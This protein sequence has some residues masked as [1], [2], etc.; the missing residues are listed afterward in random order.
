MRLDLFY[1][2]RNHGFCYEIKF[3]ALKQLIDYKKKRAE[4]KDKKDVSLLD[5]LIRLIDLTRVAGAGIV[6]SV[7]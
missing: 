1:D 3:V 5:R 7:P 2:P 6:T 4:L